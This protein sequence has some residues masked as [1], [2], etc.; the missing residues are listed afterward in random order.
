MAEEDKILEIMRYML[1]NPEK[2]PVAHYE[3]K[4][5]KE[6]WR[7]FSQFA[8]GSTEPYAHELEKQ[9][10]KLTALGVREFYRMKKDNAMLKRTDSL[11][12][13][14]MGLAIS[15]VTLAFV[16]LLQWTTVSWGDAELTVFRVIFAVLLFVAL[17]LSLSSMEKFGLSK[18]KMFFDK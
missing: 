11:T 10:L 16:T 9:N 12:L 4:F 18:I 1:L 7:I 8:M 13:G 15:T 17:I 2:Y 14:N 6:G 3:E 5:T